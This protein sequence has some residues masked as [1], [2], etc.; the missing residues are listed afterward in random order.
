[1]KILV[2]GATGFV[3]RYT[4][5]A[6]VEAGHH[7]RALV[8]PAGSTAPLGRFA[9]HPAVELVR[10]DLRSPDGLDEVV[11]DLDAVVHLA[12]A[13]AGDFAT[14]FAGT[15][16]ATENLLGAMRRAG[17]GLLVGVSTFSVYD[18]RAMANGELV[19]ED[20]PIDE[21]PANRDEY[22]QTKLIQEKLYR[23]FTLDEPW[24]GRGDARVVIVRPGMIYGRDNLWHALLGADIGPRFL[25]IG[26]KATMPLTYVENCADA[27]VLAAEA[28]AA[29]PCSVDGEVIN[30]VDDDL[31]TQ[32]DYARAVEQA[33][34]A[35]ASV[36]VPWP[37]MNGAAALLERGNDLLFDG[38]AKFP[39]IVV[40]DRLHARFKPLTYSN[41]TAKRLL[42]WKPNLD[43][44]AAIARSVGPDPVLAAPPEPDDG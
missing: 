41:A 4:V 12:A 7:V 34:E 40:P 22:A 16:L 11:A 18:Y 30:V 44:A 21:T 28:L 17:V 15:V 3:G 24:T 27:F 1:M 33:I 37:M 10:A 36:S 2:T 42:G 20:S 38:R 14:Q 23:R 6:A 5:A 39:G 35:P 25:K 32:A 8:R 29:D 19:T 9:D 43:L 26:S 31:P 13:K